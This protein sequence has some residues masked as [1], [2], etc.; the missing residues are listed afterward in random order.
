MDNTVLIVDDSLYMREL[1]KE[2][3]SSKGYEV[4]GEAATGEEALDMAF[5]LLPDYITLDNI[6]PD[7]IGTDILSVFKEEGLS[8]KVLMISAVGQ[9]AVVEEVMRLGAV[10]YLVKPFEQN[11]L[12]QAIDAAN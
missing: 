11:Q 5:D 12:V 9:Q 4:V 2:A 8:S 1:I 10:G 7:M 6:L 3:L